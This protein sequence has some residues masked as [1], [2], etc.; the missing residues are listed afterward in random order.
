MVWCFNELAL[1][2]HLRLGEACYDATT[3]NRCNKKSQPFQGAPLY[4]ANEY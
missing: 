3:A 2:S 4:I 1:H